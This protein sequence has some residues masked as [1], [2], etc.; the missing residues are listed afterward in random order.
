MKVK[1]IIIRVVRRAYRIITRRKF[2]APECDCDRQS[3][4]DKIYEL[5]ASGKP[6]MIA[7]FGTVE[8]NCITNYL[9]VHSDKSYWGRIIDFIKDNTHTPWWYDKIF[10]HLSNN[11]GVINANQE[12]AEKFSERY[13]Q[14]IPEIDLLACHQYYEKFMPLRD[15]IQR[16]QLEMLYPFFVERPWTRIL[17]GKKVLVVHPFVD[18][19]RS[20]YQKRELLFSNPDVLPEFELKTLKAVQTI[21]GT[22]SEFASWFDALKYMEDEIDKIDF[23][24]A[25]IGCGAYGLPLAAHVKRIGKQAVHIAGG[26]QLLFGILGKRWTEQYQGSLHYRPGIIISLDYHPLFNEYWVSPSRHEKPKGSEKV[27]GGCYW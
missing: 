23:D 20:Q 22:K 18:T 10:S 26:T 8:I 19:I 25:I 13:I 11:A 14:D 5:L 12:V 2:Y 9:C 16:V 27:E 24:I 1:D 15:D 4:N 7:R 21:A 3:S 17:K 6:C